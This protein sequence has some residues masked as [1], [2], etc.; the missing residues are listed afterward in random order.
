MHTCV[1]LV[2]GLTVAG[3]EGSGELWQKRCGGQAGTEVLHIG[4]VGGR[5]GLG[6]RGGGAAQLGTALGFKFITG[7]LWA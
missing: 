6:W 5:G 4:Q 2:K 3:Q 1:C 7:S